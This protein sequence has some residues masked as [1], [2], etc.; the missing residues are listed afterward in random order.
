MTE[1]T[2]M[3]PTGPVY[4]NDNARTDRQRPW[5]GVVDILWGLLF[6]IAIAFVGGA[7]VV[8]VAAAIAGDDLAGISSSELPVYALF[9][10]TLVQQGAQGAWPWLVSKR[11]GLGM[12]L[13]WKFKFDLPKDIGYGLLLAVACLVGAAVATQ[14]AG[15]IVGLDDT[16]EASNTAI[17]SD[18]EGSPWL[19][20]M[21]FV[22]VIGAPFT[23][24]LL[25]RGMF[26]RA[27]Q[28][29]LGAGL[30]IVLST[31]LFTLPHV[32][33]GAT[34][35]E[36]VVLWSAIFVIGLILAFG[37]VQLDSLGPPIIGHILFNGVGTLAA[38]LA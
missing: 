1:S 5:W 21:I 29:R 20:G 18:N 7:V 24:E 2:A 26:L 27:F 38:L 36:A 11:K 3:P 15:A 8:L 12:A 23:E 22:V 25:F 14:L 9:L 10:A 28:K 6:V 19:I 16:S 4:Y 34:L 13:D 37:A 31:V 17:I 32:V 30:A 33:A 35:D